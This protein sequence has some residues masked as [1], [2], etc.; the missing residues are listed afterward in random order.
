MGR[1]CRSNMFVG[2]ER[3]PK[4]P[5]KIPETNPGCGQ[6]LRK[7]FPKTFPDM[8]LI[9]IEIGMFFGR[10]TQ[11]KKW[12]SQGNSHV[13]HFCFFGYFYG[14]YDEKNRRKAPCNYSA[15]TWTYNFSISLW[16][17]LRTMTFMI[18]WF[19]GFWNNIR[20]GPSWP[21]AMGREP[22]VMPRI[23]RKFIN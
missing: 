17:N 19:V 5:G 23:N 8:F 11:N 7:R 13:L 9:E 3:S 20:A 18:S 15:P 1:T 2:Q 16:E 22:N 21:W 10:T 6:E 14:K 12:K 4:V